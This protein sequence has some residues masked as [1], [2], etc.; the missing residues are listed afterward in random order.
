MSGD[1]TGMAALSATSLLGV[2]APELIMSSL[3]LS[4]N[5]S[6]VAERLTRAEHTTNRPVYQ[7][8]LALSDV[9]LLV[10]RSALIP[11]CLNRAPGLNPSSHLREQLRL[12]PKFELFG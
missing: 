11:L 2:G 10:S 1:A 8:L 7:H 6:N 9:E 5:P 4:P 12:E 3:D